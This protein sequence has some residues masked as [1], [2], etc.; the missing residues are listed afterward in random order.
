MI[1]TAKCKD[2]ANWTK[3]CTVMEADREAIRRHGE[4]VLERMW[5]L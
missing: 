5:N 3:Q 1:W 4:M 2:D